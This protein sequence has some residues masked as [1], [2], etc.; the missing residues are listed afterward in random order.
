M[1]YDL[2]FVRELGGCGNPKRALYRCSC[3]KDVVTN[4]ASV[5]AGHT[6]SCGHRRG[7]SH[8]CG[9]RTRTPEY[10]A[11]CAMKQR[12]SESGA[13]PE[14]YIQRG[15][16]VC[17]SWLWSFTRFLEDV[18]PRPR[19]GMTIERIDNDK[20]YEPGNVRWATMAEQSRNKCNNRRLTLH[21]FTLTI[22]EWERL[23][24]RD[25]HTIHDRLKR[26]LT[27]EQA[28]FLDGRT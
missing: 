3:G 24:G 27:P 12:V 19:E 16:R 9:G 8:G 1:P 14:R 5:K 23:T 7:E 15:I 6:K 21:G 20:G 4:P 10:A 17:D 25:R 22:G 18:G 2:A 11:W 26:G 13:A 28:V